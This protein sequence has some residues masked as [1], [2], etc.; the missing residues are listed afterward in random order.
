MP[1][2][3]QRREGEE[4]TIRPAEEIR[5]VLLPAALAEAVPFVE[6]VGRHQAAPSGEGGAEG[7]LLGRALAADVDD[8]R[9]VLGILDPAGDEA[10]A[11]QDELARALFEPDHRH[12]LRRRDVVARRKVRLLAIGEGLAHRFRRQGYGVAA[13]HVLFSRRSDVSDQYF[14]W[15]W[16]RIF[17]AISRPPG[18]LLPQDQMRRTWRPALELH[19][20]RC[21]CRRTI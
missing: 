6:P 16:P 21:A 7:R 18:C 14:I 5:P 11:H 9:E 12:R 3:P 2:L 1:G 15:V 20:R 13:T 8:Q 17:P 10:P 19:L 4:A